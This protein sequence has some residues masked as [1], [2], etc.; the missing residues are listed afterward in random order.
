M[1][2]GN[3][4]PWPDR[5]RSQ[6]F[7]F[8]LQGRVKRPNGRNYFAA[9]EEEAA[10]E[11]AG[12]EAAAE[13]AAEEAG[14]EAAAEAAAE[15][16]AMEA[17]AEEAGAEAATDAAAEEAG[18]EAGAEACL[19][20]ATAI[21]ATAAAATILR[22]VFICNKPRIVIRRTTDL[23]FYGF[24]PDTAVMQKVCVPEGPCHSMPEIPLRSRY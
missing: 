13:A 20:Q 16:A 6:G 18:A 10:A 12:A 11:E 15:E 22:A 4:K 8:R 17:A 3:K 14:A 2:E 23:N 19:E 1:P 7:S 5:V 21:M 9:A 24:Q